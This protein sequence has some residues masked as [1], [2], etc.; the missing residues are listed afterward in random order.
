MIRAFF[1]NMR[2]AFGTFIAN[3]LRTLLTLLGIIIGVSTVMTMM[4]LLEGLR[5]KVNK[6]M[7]SLGANVFRVDKWPSGM[8]FG[9]DRLNWNK[10]AAR[11]PLTVEDKRALLE[12]C[13]SVLRTAAA[14]WQP[15]QKLKTANAET[16]G[17]VFIVGTT[18]EYTDTSG[19]TVAS[20]ALLQ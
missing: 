2:L 10:I 14:S 8:H 6:D 16:Q 9:N 20:G 12:H 18:V 17:N 3:P 13:P 1:D 4:A 11:P 5:L 15:A 19:V 7:S